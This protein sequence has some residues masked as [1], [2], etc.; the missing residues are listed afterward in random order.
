MIKCKNFNSEDLKRIAR[1]VATAFLAEDG[2]FTSL[3]IDDAS[4][5]FNIIIETCYN[6]GHL[7][8]TSENEEGFCVY[9]TKSERPGF[10]PQLKMMW[11]MATQLPI[12]AGLLMMNNQSGWTPTEK[13]YTAADDFVEVFL[14]AVR[15]EFQGRGY[16]K[17]MLN[18]PF[19]LAEKR[20]TICVLDTD[21]K[22]K[23]QKYE[24][25]GMHIV[26]SKKLKSKITMYAMEK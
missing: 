10:F 1:F 8:K 7:Y 18:E 15:P 14:I 25:E 5:M 20:N 17:A 22:L 12:K 24:H 26:E 3:S 23:A 2:C 4:K 16:F 19:T 11:R 13:R 9:W 6:E 21:S